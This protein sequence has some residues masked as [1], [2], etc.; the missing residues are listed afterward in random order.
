MLDLHSVASVSYRKYKN[1][2]TSRQVVANMKCAVLLLIILVSYIDAGSDFDVCI[3][4]MI[5]LF[6]IDDNIF[7]SYQDVDCFSFTLLIDG[8][9]VYDDSYSSP[10]VLSHLSHDQGHTLFGHRLHVSHKV[11]D[12]NNHGTTEVNFQLAI[13]IITTDMLVIIMVAFTESLVHLVTI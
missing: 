4:S 2:R 9:L 8:P 5:F 11:L 13:S 12:P 1:Q 3:L 7:I 6:H 10:A